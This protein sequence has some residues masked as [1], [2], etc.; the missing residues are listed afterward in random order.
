M[1]KLNWSTLIVTLLI[2]MLALTSAFGAHNKANKL[3]A[4]L[5]EVEEGTQLL[6]ESL[7]E[8]FEENNISYHLHWLHRQD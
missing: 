5:A 6:V 4:R 3:E 7:Q 2:S 8:T 1:K